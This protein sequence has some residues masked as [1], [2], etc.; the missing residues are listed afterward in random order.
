MGNY[1]KNPLRKWRV[2]NNLSL[3]EVADLVGLSAAMLSRAERGQR[4][5]KPMTRVRIARRLGVPVRKIFDVERI[6]EDEQAGA[7]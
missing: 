3:E 5:F 4:N 1:L 2:A 6:P 7:R